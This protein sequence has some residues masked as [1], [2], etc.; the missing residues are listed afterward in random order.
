M[1]KVLKRLSDSSL[2]GNKYLPNELLEDL[3]N[4]IF[5]DKES[6][7]LNGIDQNLQN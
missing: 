1:S 7:K 4:S 3:T 5:N 2:Y 6:R